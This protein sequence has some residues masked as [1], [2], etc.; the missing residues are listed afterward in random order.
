MAL[1]CLQKF[2]VPTLT[3]FT[4][5]SKM[6]SNSYHDALLQYFDAVAE[7]VA[8]FKMADLEKFLAKLVQLIVDAR[9]SQDNLAHLAKLIAANFE[10]FKGSP[11]VLSLVQMRVNLLEGIIQPDPA[12]SWKMYG[13]VAGHPRFEKFLKSEEQ[14]VALGGFLNGVY[15]ARSFV[16]TYSGFH[17]GY[18]VTLDFRGVGSNV[19]LN[20]KKTTDYFTSKIKQLNKLRGELKSLKK[21]L[22][23]V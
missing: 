4:N 11:S 19:V 18:S 9:L 15:Q 22:A 2:I 14:Q 21:L 16:S 23:V 12:F 13:N 3:D 17:A 5:Y 7:T 20:I 8:V 10:N 1:A 6:L